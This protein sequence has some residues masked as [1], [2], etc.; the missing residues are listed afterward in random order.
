MNKLKKTGKGTDTRT[1]NRKGIRTDIQIPKNLTG[2][3]IHAETGVY[4][5]LFLY[6][7]HLFS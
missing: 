7:S 5:F 1:V 2:T 3:H 6:F 4:Y